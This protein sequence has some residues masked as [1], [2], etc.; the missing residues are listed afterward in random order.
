MRGKRQ[1]D[2]A[3]QNLEG[4]IPAHAGKTAASRTRLEQS[5]AHPRSC[6]ENTPWGWP[7]GRMTGS[8]P[9]MRGKRSLCA[10]FLVDCG[11]IPAH[12]GKTGRTRPTPAS[13]RAH[14]RSCGENSIMP[15]GMGVFRGS[16]PL[17]RGKLF[18]GLVRRGLNGLIPAHAGKTC[19]YTLTPRLVPAH[20]RSRG[21]NGIVAG[22]SLR[23]VG[24]SPLTRGK[25]PFR[26]SMRASAGLIPAH[27]GKTRPGR[28]TPSNH[29]AHPRSRGE[30]SMVVGAASAAAGSSPLTRGKR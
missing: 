7:F 11:L 3:V 5:Q 20:P 15:W 23:K 26:L 14:P 29:R 28:A 4:L 10:T 25:P 12:A 1:Q 13:R 17:M 19:G 24:S 30:N 16:S 2:V 18:G 6:G 22:D 9:L 8:S 21:E 27:A